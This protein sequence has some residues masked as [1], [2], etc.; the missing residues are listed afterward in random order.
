MVWVVEGAAA[1]AAAERR[2]GEGPRWRRE[3]KAYKWKEKERRE[4][5]LVGDEARRET[6]VKGQLSGVI[7]IPYRGDSVVAQWPGRCVAREEDETY[8]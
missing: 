6:V 4:L 1:P 3:E 5:V 2:R 7:S 8:F